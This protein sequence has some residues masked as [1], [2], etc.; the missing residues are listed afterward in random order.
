MAMSVEMELIGA[1]LAADGESVS[2][3]VEQRM[4]NDTS[5]AVV[6]KKTATIIIDEDS[7]LFDAAEILRSRYDAA[8]R[9]GNLVMAS[10]QLGKL[11]GKSIVT[12]LSGD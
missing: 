9:W 11:V 3:T 6:A 2:V 4:V 7:R 1:E 5:K 10:R 12:T 8:V